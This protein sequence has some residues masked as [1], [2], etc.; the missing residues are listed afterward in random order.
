MTRRG[1]PFYH[2][3]Q[4]IYLGILPLGEEKLFVDRHHGIVFLVLE[5]WK[6]YQVDDWRIVFS[7]SGDGRALI[8]MTYDKGEIVPRKIFRED[9]F[10]CV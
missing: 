5:G 4:H 9:C 3:T 1:N 6:M 7:L 10:T 2:C 8:A